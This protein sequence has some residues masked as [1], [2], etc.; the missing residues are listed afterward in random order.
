[1]PRVRTKIC[2]IT[3][4]EDA[5]TAA[6]AGTDAIG[7]NFFE[8]SPRYVSPENGK[9]I[10]ET[11]PAFVNRVGLFVNANA[12]KI[13]AVM[14]TVP[15][16]TLQFHG[17]ETPE[18]CASFGLPYVKSVGMRPGV[19]LSVE[20]KRYRTA[21]ALLLDQFDRT[22]WGGTGEQFDWHLVPDERP[23]PL[24][25]AGGLSAENVAEALRKVRPYAVDVSG[26]VEVSPGVKDPVKIRAFIR[27]VAS[28]QHSQ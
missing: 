20:A 1:M 14:S 22:R 27:G 17:D 5:L 13:Q 15:L 28:V 18:F 3:R 26:G 21:A 9:A 8:P 19:N 16:D 6:R 24:I 11:L 4:I 2:G 7:L 23:M 10:A 25:L 12:E